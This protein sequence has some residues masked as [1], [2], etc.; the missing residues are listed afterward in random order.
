MS[1]CD[2]CC[3]KSRPQSMDLACDRVFTGSSSFLLGA[4]PSGG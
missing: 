1:A 3:L 2:R 4:F